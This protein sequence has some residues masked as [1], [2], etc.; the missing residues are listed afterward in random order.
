MLTHSKALAKAVGATVEH[1]PSPK[2]KFNLLAVKK[3]KRI[4]GPSW[5]YQDLPSR[6]V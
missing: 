4:M 5:W 3:S 2:A 1:S 6:N